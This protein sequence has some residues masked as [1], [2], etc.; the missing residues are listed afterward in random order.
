LPRRDFVADI[1]RKLDRAG[2][3]I[4]DAL[5]VSADQWWSYVGELEGC[6]GSSS[7]PYL[8]GDSSPVAATA[9]FAGMVA[10]PDRDA[11]V[12][13]LRPEDGTARAR[14]L[15]Q[16]YAEED[17]ALQAV[18]DG[19]AAHRQRSLKR[20][21]FAD[22]READRALFPHS[23][24]RNADDVLCRHAVALGDIAIRDALW[25][26]I[27]QGRLDGR[28]FWQL[29][30]RRLPAP[31]D[32]APLFLFGWAAWREGNGSLAAMAAEQALDSDPAYTAADL[33]LSAVRHGLDPFRTPKLRGARST[34]TSEGE[35][36]S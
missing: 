22:A 34:L 13:V 19:R 30:A 11:L 16:I 29:M 20:A 17:A 8:P 23:A 9:T 28:T 25:L 32:C 2:F 4:L 24:A 1:C 21:L 35:R 18:L 7:G 31:Y 36:A 33:L 14:R 15:P 5:L 26:A 3:A 10:H 27:D 12:A 6:A